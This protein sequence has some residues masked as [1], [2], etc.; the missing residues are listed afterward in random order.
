MDTVNVFT[1][2]R[3]RG[4]IVVCRVVMSNHGKGEKKSIPHRKECRNERKTHLDNK[5]R[6]V[7]K[8]INRQQ[9]SKTTHLPINL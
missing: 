9:N 4:V 2:R 5:K 1:S 7:S 3:V 6:Q 8:W